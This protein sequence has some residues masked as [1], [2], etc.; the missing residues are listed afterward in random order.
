MKNK[1]FSILLC[2]C[3][4]FT[5]VACGEAEK[6]AERP[7]PDPPVVDPVGPDEEFKPWED[8]P[9]ATEPVDLNEQIL[10]GSW[11]TY[12]RYNIASHDTQMR[13]LA[14]AGINFNLFPFQWDTE[15]WDSIEDWKQID[16]LCRKYRIVYGICANEDLNGANRFSLSLIHI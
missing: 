9:E 10:I 15:N 6:E 14:Q 16:E 1:I 8:I 12:Y 3:L 11:V 7:K 5:L 4:L 2:F 13:R